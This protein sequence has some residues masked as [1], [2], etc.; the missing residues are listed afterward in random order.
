MKITHYQVA[1]EATERGWE[2]ISESYHNL[3][4][5]LE[6]KCPK[7]HLVHIPYKD[8]RIKHSCYECEKEPFDSSRSSIEKTGQKRT[9]IFDQATKTSGWA[10]FDGVKLNDFGAKN[11]SG[12]TTDIRINKTKKWIE[13]MIT[14][15]QPDV[16]AIEDI[17]YKEC[18]KSQAAGPENLLMVFKVLAK[19][20]GVI[21]DTLYEKKI[22]YYICP[23]AK[24]RE[25]CEVKGVSRSDKKRSAQLQVE[26]KYGVQVGQDEADVI[27]I[28]RYVTCSLLAENMIVDFADLIAKESP[29]EEKYFDEGDLALKEL[30]IDI[31]KLD[32]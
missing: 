25:F 29:K 1:Q 8:W 14:M 32:I 27:C 16:V 13:E 12:S 11:I 22:K 15:W 7:G 5:D 3:N 28:G 10:V 9:L 30:G 26:K 20:Q 23:P 24:W 6:F 19:L 18:E 31:D 21:C 4:E 2:L 17:F